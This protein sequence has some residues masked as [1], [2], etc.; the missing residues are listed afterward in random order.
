[1]A[2]QQMQSEMAVE[3][4]RIRLPEGADAMVTLLGRSRPQSDAEAFALLRRSF[5]ASALC[6][7]VAAVGRWRTG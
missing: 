2:Q 7:R 4:H 1:M 5:P 6:E 3:P